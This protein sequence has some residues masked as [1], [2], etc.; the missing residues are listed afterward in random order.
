MRQE[1]QDTI[2]KDATELQARIEST[3]FVQDGAGCRSN[4]PEEAIQ[5]YANYALRPLGLAADKA[6]RQ[7]IRATYD[8]CRKV[9]QP[10]RSRQ[11]EV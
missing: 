2:D 4:R 5:A 7:T 9:G 3:K 1:V 6:A 8:R 10:F 11:R